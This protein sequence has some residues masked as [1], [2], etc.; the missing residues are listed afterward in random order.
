M[1]T[2]VLTNLVL[3]HGAW[4]TS[5]SWDQLKLVWDSPSVT[6]STIDLPS[7]DGTGNL[8]RDADA[9]AS[10]CRG[11]NGPTILLGHSYGGAVITQAA[12]NVPDLEGLIYL[13]AMKPKLGESVAQLGRRS[14]V[15]SD[16]DAAIFVSN[17]QMSL[18][19]A[20]AIGVLYD[21]VTDELE[22]LLLHEIHPQ[23]VSTFT[24]ALS[25]DVPTNVSTSY[26]LC[27][28]DR[29]I[30]PALQH[31]IA[32]TCDTTLELATGHCPNVDA[33]F[34]LQERI[35]TSLKYINFEK[36]GSPNC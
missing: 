14:P 9:V 10:H 4:H 23:S 19:L 2:S 36:T 20:L 6:L 21:N 12:R 11:L 1:N 17:N 35:E 3:V 33:P 30:A 22:K 13:A 28:R 8:S 32:L 15:G 27:T 7:V 34:L 29:T 31:V 26:V 18:D 25:S 5:A 24:E 16:L